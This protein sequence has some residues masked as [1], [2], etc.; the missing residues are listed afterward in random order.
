MVINVP[1]RAVTSNSAG[2]LKVPTGGNIIC[3]VLVLNPVWSTVTV[4]PDGPVG[5]IVPKLRCCNVL[6]VTEMGF[7][8]FSCP[9][10]IKE[11]SNP[12]VKHKKNIISLPN[13]THDLEL[14]II[15]S[16]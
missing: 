13:S 4:P 6:T 10:E 1:G 14:F 5:I 9:L 7:G 12:L 15:F 2:L 3:P 11:T 16:Y 8:G